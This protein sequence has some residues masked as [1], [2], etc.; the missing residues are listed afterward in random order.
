MTLFT[1][2]QGREP[3][4]VR[5]T[6]YFCICLLR[7]R[8]KKNSWRYTVW[9]PVTPPVLSISGVRTPRIYQ[10]PLCLSLC[11]RFSIRQTVPLY[12]HTSFCFIPPS[13]PGT[14]TPINS[15]LDSFPFLDEHVTRTPSSR[16]PKLL[17]V[18]FSGHTD[19]FSLTPFLLP[20]SHLPRPPFST[21]Y[22][23]GAVRKP[24]ISLYSR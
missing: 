1:R 8:F 9:T 2:C 14:S 17:L 22:D 16:K 6:L 12:L 24:R 20:S 15:S 21:Y 11:I 5:S 18:P 7:K 3:P 19:P 10:L 13:L 4:C 23:I